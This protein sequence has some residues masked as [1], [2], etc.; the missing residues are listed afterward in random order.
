MLGLHQEEL[1][2]EGQVGGLRG[3]CGERCGSSQTASQFEYGV[4][5][6]VGLVLLQEQG[7]CLGNVRLH[8]KGGLFE[9]SQV[10]QVCPAGRQMLVEDIPS[11]SEDLQ[12]EKVIAVAVV[13][14]SAGFAQQAVDNVAVVDL[15]M[16]GAWHARHG[17][18]AL[19]GVPDFNVPF[20]D[21]NG[22]ALAFQPAGDAVAVAAH[23]KNSIL[24]DPHVQFAHLWPGLGCERFHHRNF[25]V[26]FGLSRG[27]AFFH[28]VE[29]EGFVGFDAL[30]IAAAAQEQVLPHCPF[31]SAV[32]G[33][34]VAVFVGA[35]Q[36]DCARLQS[37]VRQQ[38][39]VLLVVTAFARTLLSV[40]RSQFVGGGGGMVGL[41]RLRH[42]PKFEQGA[43]QS[44]ADRE[45][46]FTLHHASP[47]NTGSIL[48]YTGP[49][50]R[51]IWQYPMDDS[52]A[53]EIQLTPPPIG[54]SF[55]ISPNGNW[56]VYTY[57]YYPGKTDEAVTPGIYV[58]NL[59]EGSSQL[60]ASA[61]PYGLP[62]S[63]YW[64]TDN[65]HFIFETEQSHL[66][67]GNVNGEIVPL[68]GGQFL[69]WIDA[70]HYLY[71]K[72]AIGEI[73]KE[74]DLIAVSIPASIKYINPDYFTFV[75]VKREVREEK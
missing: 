55:T 53:I 31:Q 9:D 3:K 43:L 6:P 5:I 35:G 2:V 30:E 18:N 64:S 54:D 13:A 34:N 12:R 58:G 72:V 27:V 36:M 26:Q 46:R 40:C 50:A 74:A 20:V 70:S 49:E 52:P 57:Y 15:V 24:P 25:F 4:F 1:V 32:G 39:Q 28:D 16:V 56:V 21:A 71:G 10:G 42:I 51:T 23:P 37:V 33:F 8:P 44:Q 45:Q 66:F 29:Q 22:G 63:F 75:F 48:D 60:V 47:I 67:L 38:L 11:L 7:E 68:A 62:Y 14:K 65:T 41:V 19:V 69:G 17:L 59:R 61:Q 73:G